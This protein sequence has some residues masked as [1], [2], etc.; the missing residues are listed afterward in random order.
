MRLI[1]QIVKQIL[2]VVGLGLIA[3]TAT[4]SVNNPENGKEYTLLERPQPTD[5]GKKIEVI[6]FFAYYCPH[7]YVLDPILTEWVKKQG[8]NITFKRVHVSDSRVVPHQKLFYA[9]EAM[10]KLEEF[11]IK[12]FNTFHVEHNRLQTDGEVLDFVTKAGIDK[13]KFL[14]VYNSFSIQ[15]KLN[16]S[17]QLMTSYQIDSWPKIAVDG[18][19]MTSP[20]MAGAGMGRVTE[21]AQNLALMP[22]LDALIA[23]IQKEK[24][25]TVAVDPV[26]TPAKKK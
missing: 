24:N 6:E 20:A 15:S 11:H 7:C 23:K 13:Q 19:Y 1:R 10:G 12:I 8:D 21:Q 4:A 26:K 14:D 5:S 18:R 22:V 16:R 25:V 9:L 3:A 2:M 17:A